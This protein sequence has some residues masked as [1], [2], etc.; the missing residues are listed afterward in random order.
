V[1]LTSPANG[2][3]VHGTVDLTATAADDVGV[4]KVEWLVNGTVLAGKA[5]APYTFGWGS[6]PSGQVVITARAVDA[7][8]N[9]ATS[10][11]TVTV[12]NTPPDT[13]LT[14]TPANVAPETATFAFAAS[15]TGSTFECSLDGAAFAACPSPVSYAGLTPGSHTFAVRAVD[16]VGNVDPTPASSTWTVVDTTPPD[17]SITSG[18]SGT[19]SSTAASFSFS[20]TEPG[21]FS[22]SLDGEVYAACTPPQAYSSLA[23]GTHTFAVR[24][25]DAAGN[26]DPS[27]ATRTWTVSLAPTNDLFANAQTINGKPGSTAGSNFGATAEP[28]EPSHAA[29]PGGHSVWYR[30]RA[31]STGAVTFETVGS[32][33]DT[34]LAAYRG[35]SVG[36]LTPV[37][38]NDNLGPGVPQSRIKF[39]AY[40][41]VTYRI[42]VDGS[43]GAS[44]S[45]VL[46]WR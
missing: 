28:G 5:V 24:A 4:G 14:S 3:V 37:A 35:S 9:T 11:V 34:L 32:G 7:A 2:A 8:R 15:E 40:A 16:A 21:S 18:P 23:A 10:S 22:C 46:A 39:T 43:Y 41:G 20:A 30:W 44:G 13:A 45:V 36:A 19:V 25:T 33:F 27:P 6:G 1:K 26:T 31:P 38:A 29:V 17:T 42:A 12:D